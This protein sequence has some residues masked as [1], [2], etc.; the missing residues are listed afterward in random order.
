MILM[1]A[2]S[3][4]IISPTPQSTLNYTQVL[5][6]W[7]QIPGVELYNLQVYTNEA[8]LLINIETESLTYLSTSELHWSD[9]FYFAVRDAENTSNSTLVN[10]FHIAIYLHLPVKSLMDP[11]TV[12]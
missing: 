4:D 5:F 12:L 7:E 6:E 2:I 1:G 10:Y 8:D 11:Y 9:L 3:A